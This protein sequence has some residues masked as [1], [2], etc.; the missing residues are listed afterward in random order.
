MRALSSKILSLV[1][2]LFLLGCAHASSDT[3]SDLLPMYG[4]ER[5]LTKT[6][7]MLAA[8]QKFLAMVHEKGF[9][10]E[11]A[12]KKS[13]QL[14]WSYL[15]KGDPVTAM[16][17]FNQ[18][19]LTDPN[20][21]EAYHGF[22]VVAADQKKPPADVRHLFDLAVALPGTDASSYVDYGRYLWMQ[23]RRDEALAILQRGLNV[24]PHARNAQRHMAV[25]SAEMGD[26]ANA[27]TFGKGA[28]ANGDDLPQNVAD[29]LCQ[30]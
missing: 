4:T 20:N 23:G 26:K 29:S 22:A 17:R 12:S 25:I 16:K 30:P 13:S 5:G 9:T 11:T 14:G 19:W 2:T 10:D 15:A 6:P 18:A 24:D 21:G 3:A 28:I 8:D 7:E 27:C 1:C